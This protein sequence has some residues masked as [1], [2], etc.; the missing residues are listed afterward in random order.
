MN[1]RFI[2]AFSL[3]I[4]GAGALMM[5]QKTEARAELCQG[6]RIC[7]WS[8]PANISLYCATV[9]GC[10]GGDGAFTCAAGS[11]GSCDFWW[12]GDEDDLGW[13]WDVVNCG[14]PA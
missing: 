11:G 4:I 3:L 10:E 1:E 14:G 9:A 8:C 5:P 7:T 13:A 12:G 6:T 2:Q